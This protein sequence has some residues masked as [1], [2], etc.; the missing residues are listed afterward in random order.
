MKKILAI[1]PLAFACVPSGSFAAE[2]LYGRI[3]TGYSWSSDMDRDLGNNDA[4]NSAIL[5]GGIGYHINDH[6]RT[7]A[8]IS[9]RGWYKYEGSTT[10][11]S[12]T[13]SGTADISSVVGMV[14]AYYDIGHYDRFT[15]YIGGGIGFSS[16]HVKSADLSLN[17]AGV[18]GIDG[19]THTSF[20]WQLGAGTA[21]N[22]AHG[23]DLDIGYRYIDMG[24]AKT[25]DT[26]TI[27]GTP[28]AGA[29]LQGNLRASEAQVG[30]RAAF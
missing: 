8:T 27:A 16:N 24:T 29:T 5:G 15:P 21:I 18:G 2:G 1:L 17:G 22:V 23:I 10:I 28:I 12:A 25:G 3:D 11:G 9:Y 30:L 20:A 13:L 19:N 7:D 14:N 6:L 4:G 26:A